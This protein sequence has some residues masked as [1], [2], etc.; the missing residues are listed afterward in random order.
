MAEKALVLG[1]S[2]IAVGQGLVM[3]PNWVELARDGHTAQIATVLNPINVPQLAIPDKLWTVIEE[4]K[5]W[6]PLKQENEAV[7]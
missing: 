1:L 5:G 4:T 7:A 3:N 6:F 2:L